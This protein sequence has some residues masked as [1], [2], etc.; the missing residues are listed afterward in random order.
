IR[1]ATG[2]PLLKELL[3]LV[4]TDEA[5]HVHYGVLALEQ[6]YRGELSDRER[7]EREAWAFEMSLLLRNRFLMHELYDESYAHELSRSE[8]DRL[9]LKSHLMTSFRRTM[10]KRIIPNLKRI[11]LLSDRI[12][13]HYDQLGL[14]AFENSKAAPDL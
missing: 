3:R 9:V 14:L 7:R 1:H 10:F 11:G 4:I 5:R 6:F 8:W 2:E 12:R 13:P